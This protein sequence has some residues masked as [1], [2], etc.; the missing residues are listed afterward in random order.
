MTDPQ[1]EGAAP[2]EAPK[3]A[4]KPRGHRRPVIKRKVKRKERE[5][6]LQA[7]DEFQERG[8]PVVDWVVSRWRF[9]A[10]GVGGVL[11]VLAVVGLLGRAENS[12]NLVAAGELAEALLKLP[13]ITGFD[14]DLSEKQTEVD[15]ALAELDKVIAAN[16]GS[17]QA[18]QARVEAGNAAY[19]SAAYEAA[20]GYYDAAS[21]ADG[22]TG[23]LARSGA[24]Y[25]LEALERHDEAIAKFE[26]VHKGA[27][28]KAKEQ[29]V[30]NLGRVYEAKGD[31]AKAASLYAAFETEFPDSSRLADVQAKA[32][33]LKAASPQGSQPSE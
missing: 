15:A 30:L 33:A 14:A 7:P 11:L 16:D 2:P 5:E 3:P 22:L 29:A 32:A 31:S 28:G 10:G 23:E 13:D 25:A 19:R 12:R 8:R 20:L 24:G 17:P 18:D 26:A 27:E 9:I 6:E 1:T 4:P 21:K